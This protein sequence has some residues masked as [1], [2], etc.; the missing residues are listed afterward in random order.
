MA[1]RLSGVISSVISG[2]ISL[3]L[4]PSSVSLCE[5]DI[6]GAR[7]PGSDAR[8]LASCLSCSDLP[9]IWVPDEMAD[10]ETGAGAGD[11]P[12]RSS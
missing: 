5:N 7:S 4:D 2:W 3:A 10:T 9:R 11:T 12:R 1:D 6:T 8:A